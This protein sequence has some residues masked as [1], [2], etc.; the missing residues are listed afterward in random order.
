[1]AAEVL[2]TALARSRNQDPASLTPVFTELF[3]Q[4]ESPSAFEPSRF[5]AA[6]R[7]AEGAIR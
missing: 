1:M 6:M 7:K 5:V 3:K 4:F 2:A